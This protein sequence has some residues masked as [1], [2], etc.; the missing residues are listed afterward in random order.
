MKKTNLIIAIIFVGFVANA[1]ITL[2]YETHAL[3]AN[4]E[5]TT[6]FV[7]NTEA[8]E[9]GENQI[10]DF[11]NFECGQEKS[12]EIIS[13]NDVPEHLQNFTNITITDGD[14]YFY[15]D[16][17]EYGIDYYG[18]ITPNAVINYNEPIEK[19]NYPFT[20]GDQTEGE[21]T[22]TGLY[23]GRVE[24]DIYGTYSIEADGYGTIVLPGDVTLSNV[25]RVKTINNTFEISCKT[26][27]TQNVKY[28]WFSADYRYPIMVVTENTKI[29]NGEIT[30]TKTGYYNERAFQ[31][32]VEQTNKQLANYSI[33]VYPNP[34][35][36]FVNINYD[37]PQKTKVN[38][39][40][41]DISGAKVA[42]IVE[43]QEQK[44]SQTQT[45]T[46]NLAVGTYF[47]KM[48]LG[49]EIIFKKIVLVN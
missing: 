22:G 9:A 25:L 8:G 2:N 40:V 41:F 48:N 38:I 10:W 27:E 14:N 34:F 44:G 21:F 39:E 28:L 45:F 26:T 23:Y 3:Q 36:E 6:Q 42:T 4:Y 49:N 46:P 29:E 37:L 30:V 1:Q 35:T 5:H 15:F 20:Y 7:E 17:D 19:M 32:G 47:I 18:L 24:T 12:S 16:V 33:T 43:N 31:T 11:S 13:E